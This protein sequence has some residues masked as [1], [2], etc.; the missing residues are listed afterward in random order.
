PGSSARRPGRPRRGGRR[1]GCRRGASYQGLV[2]RAV[3]NGGRRVG[4]RDGEA[5]TRAVGVGRVDPDAAAVVFD[6]LLAQREADTGS[7]VG[8]AAVQPLEDDEDLVLE[9][10]GDADAV[11]GDTEA[12]GAGVLRVS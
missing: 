11:V 4:G 2:L 7:T 5:E 10:A 3:V 6:D 12:P 1:W 9:L 8:I